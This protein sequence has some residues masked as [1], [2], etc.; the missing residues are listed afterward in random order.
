MKLSALFALGLT[1]LTVAG[2]M[3]TGR[4]ACVPEPQIVDSRNLLVNGEFNF[5][6]LTP[7]RHGMAVSY[8]AD[9]VPFWNADT[10]KSLRVM[11]DSH[12]PA[13]VRPPFSVPCGVELNPGQSF[14]QFFTLP[15]ADL[16]YGDKIHAFQYFLILNRGMQ[17]LDFQ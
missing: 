5:H 10:A 11:R 7:H 17:P 15:E 4:T 8:L 2:C 13:S 12:I 1:L 6:S 16:L 9:Y 3:Q 14:H